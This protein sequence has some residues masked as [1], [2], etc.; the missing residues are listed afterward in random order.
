MHCVHCGN[1]TRDCPIT[2][3]DGWRDE[4]CS[5]YMHGDLF[6]GCPDG[7]HQAEP[8]NRVLSETLTAYR[9]TANCDKRPTED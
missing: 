5:G 9:A 6:H 1:L 2:G 4:P 3:C 7:R 8:S